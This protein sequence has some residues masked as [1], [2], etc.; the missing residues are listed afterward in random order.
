LDPFYQKVVQNGKTFAILEDL[1]IPEMVK[2]NR[3]NIRE[4]QH[5]YYLK[6][7]KEENSQFLPNVCRAA[8]PQF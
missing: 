3:K 4:M 5:F 2:R 6:E 1:N 7:K 8:T